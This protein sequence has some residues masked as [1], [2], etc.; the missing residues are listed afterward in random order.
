M[1]RWY[2]IW[3]L[4]AWN[5]H[6]EQ[7]VVCLPCCSI[8]C[9]GNTPSKGGSLR[10]QSAASLVHQPTESPYMAQSIRLLYWPFISICKAKMEEPRWLNSAFQLGV[11]H[12]H[13]LL[14]FCHFPQYQTADQGALTVLRDEAKLWRQEVTM[15]LNKTTEKSKVST[16]ALSFTIDGLWPTGRNVWTAWVQECSR[17]PLQLSREQ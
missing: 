4:S 16:C 12:L 17:S 7:F 9:T 6:R 1:L 13:L 8:Q 10:S 3:G 2:C 14:Y 5:Y 15:E 11:V